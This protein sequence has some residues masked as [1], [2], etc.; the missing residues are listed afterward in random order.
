[1]GSGSQNTII[2]REQIEKAWELQNHDG[3]SIYSD[4]SSFDGSRKHAIMENFNEEYTPR[5]PDD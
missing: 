2:N 1:V 3:I 4:I 5:E